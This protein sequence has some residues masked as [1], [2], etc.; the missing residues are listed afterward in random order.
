M[1]VVKYNWVEIKSEYLKSDIEEA[2]Q[3][4]ISYLGVAPKNAA[5][6]SFAKATKGWREDKLKFRQDQAN[7]ARQKIINNVDVQEQTQLILKAK[8]YALKAIIAR[9]QTNN[10][11]L[12]MNELKIGLDALKR[13][14][15]EPL[16]IDKLSADVKSDMQIIINTNRKVNDD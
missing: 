12:S 11:S 1:P 4:L 5:N 7:K 9:L 2:S 10:K 14:L 15:G 16:N 13:E 3:F 8:D 6:G